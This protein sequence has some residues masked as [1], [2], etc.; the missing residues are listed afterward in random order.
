M[1]GA[2]DRSARPEAAPRS[3]ARI[4]FAAPAIVVLGLTL[5][6]GLP[7]AAADPLGGACY[8]LLV[9]VLVAFLAPRASRWLL[10]G[11]ALTIC[12]GIELFQLTAIPARL[13]DAVP[14]VALVLGSGYSAADLPP[15]LAGA[16]LAV[17]LDRFLRP[18]SGRGRARAGQSR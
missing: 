15:Y 8:A 5:R 4:L 13:A 17:L 9:Y 1:G 11:V 12:V 7:D 3:R 14:P 16:F 6:F 10:G 18:Q 2:P